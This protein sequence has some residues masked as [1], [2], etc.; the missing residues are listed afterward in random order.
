MRRLVITAV[1][2]SIAG[3]GLL[4][5]NA[6]ALTVPPVYLTY[7]ICNVAKSPRMV[8]TAP[9][10]ATAF[11]EDPS[12]TDT[13][14]IRYWVRFVD[15]KTGALMDGDWVYGGQGNAT[16]TAPAAFPAATL[17]GGYQYYVYDWFYLSN[18][19]I[20]QYRIA[21]YRPNWTLIDWHDYNLWSYKVKA[22][23][24]SPFGGVAEGYIGFATTCGAN[25][26]Y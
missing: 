17:I 25:P 7:G 19:V 12:K 20:A 16:E 5:A 6:S 24:P 8:Y 18:P 11:N 15:A 13:N 14:I 23:V 4:A 21:W 10:S 3:L 9:P 22:L 26:G 1:V 2:T